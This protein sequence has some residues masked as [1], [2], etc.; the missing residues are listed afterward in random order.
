MVGRAV[1]AV[2]P[3]MKQSISMKWSPDRRSIGKSV[4]FVSGEEARRVHN[5]RI[6]M[7]IRR[8][9]RGSSARPLA[10]GSSAADP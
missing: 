10:Y 3:V 2:R 9:G 5:I 7:R 8:S 4:A 6:R 1:E